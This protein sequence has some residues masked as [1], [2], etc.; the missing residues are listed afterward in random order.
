MKFEVFC[1][2]SKFKNLVFTKTKIP[3]VIKAV[4]RRKFLYKIS[5]G[6]LK[7]SDKIEVT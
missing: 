7:Y 1:E 3:N 4:F 5:V 6:S 2:K